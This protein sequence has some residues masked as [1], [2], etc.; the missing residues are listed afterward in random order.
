MD[1]LR[2]DAALS[3]PI[4]F[5]GP[6]EHGGAVFDLVSSIVTDLPY[7]DG[8]ERVS[9][10]ALTLDL[11]EWVGRPVV[12]DDGQTHD[13]TTIEATPEIQAERNIGI[14][15]SARF[16]A[17]AGERIMRIAVPKA[18]DAERIRRDYNAVSEAYRSTT[19]PATAAERAQGVD[20]VQVRRS[21]LS[22]ALIHRNRGGRAGP[23]ARVRTDGADTMAFS[24]DDFR[25]VLDGV[26]DDDDAAKAMLMAKV[27]KMGGKPAEEPSA[28][29]EPVMDGMKPEELAA[30]KA[31]AAAQKLRADAAE[32]RLL[33]IDAAEVAADL[34]LLNVT[35]DGFD[36]NAPTVE[37][38]AKAR[39][40]RD[41]AALARIRTDAIGTD[42]Q[43]NRP[44]PRVV[45]T[46]AAPKNYTPIL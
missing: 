10:D 12:I 32:R 6:G 13:G 36:A 39:T 42:P 41:A 3:R 22:L 38:V 28:E 21:P 7:G 29:I 44:S 9:V 2:T 46:D 24:L 20:R 35:C 31:D 4:V 17:E 30:I 8:V 26:P 5:D 33:V 1:P 43:G 37:S 25:A 18:R 11:D 15:S 34:K 40:A 45:K 27:A 14:V 16:D 19:R 23:R